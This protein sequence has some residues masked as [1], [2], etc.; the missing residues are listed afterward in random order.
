MA[1]ESLISKVKKCVDWRGFYK[2]SEEIL[3]NGFA[4]VTTVNGNHAL[5][6]IENGQ[7]VHHAIYEDYIFIDSSLHSPISK[8]MRRSLI[9]FIS[10]N[11]STNTLNDASVSYFNN[12]ALYGKAVFINEC[13]DSQVIDQ[14][15]RELDD[16]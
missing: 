5:C 14:L 10:T 15:G 1:I 6:R 9:E 3:D 7:P 4:L 8:E 12:V 2:L 13:T 11:A 16:L